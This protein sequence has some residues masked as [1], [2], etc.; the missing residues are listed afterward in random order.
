M[1][2]GAFTISFSGSG[3]PTGKVDEGDPFGV[4]GTSADGL[5]V[6]Q[7]RADGMTFSRLPPYVDWASL[8][9]AAR[10]FVERYL[11]TLAPAAIERAALRYINHFRLPYPSR[12]DEYF[13]AVPQLPEALPQHVS[14]L[15]L[16]LT[17]HDPPRDLSAHVTQGML[18]ELDP[19]RWGFILDIDAFRTGTMPPEVGPL[20]ETFEELR[21]FK[22]EIFFRLITD[23]TREMHD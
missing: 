2:R 11:S 13:T 20:W 12:L 8:S 1:R 15:L 6:V 16:R 14:N 5:H 19:E 23:R 10:P 7:M 17:I 4:R 3:S 9:A 21:V 22:D 18:D